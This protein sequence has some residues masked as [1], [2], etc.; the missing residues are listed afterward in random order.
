MIFSHWQV[1]MPTKP[2]VYRVDVTLDGTAHW[3]GF[4]RVTD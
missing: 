2:G 4:F 3:R 1:P